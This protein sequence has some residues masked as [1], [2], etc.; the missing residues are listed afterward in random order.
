MGTGVR[1]LDPRRV[2]LES[3]RARTRRSSSTTALCTVRGCVC[4]QQRIGADVTWASD[5]IAPESPTS[6]EFREWRYHGGD[7]SL[8]ARYRGRPPLRETPRAGSRALSCSRS[9]RRDSRQDGYRLRAAQLLRELFS[10]AF[11]L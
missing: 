4:V 10:S 9:R 7:F 1:A 2:A 5:P 8:P 6:A 3:P 11:C